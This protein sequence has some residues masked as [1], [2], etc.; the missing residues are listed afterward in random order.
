MFQATKNSEAKHKLIL[1]CHYDSKYFADFEFVGATDSSVPCAVILD[2]A[3][4]L[5]KLLS[6][7]HSSVYNDDYTLQLVFFDGEEAFVSWTATGLF[8]RAFP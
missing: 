5:D 4:K 6:A 3:I 2:V 8:G 1:A 7:R